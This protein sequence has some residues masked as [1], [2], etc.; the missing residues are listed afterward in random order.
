MKLQNGKSTNLSS[1]NGTTLHQMEQ[2]Q[3][4]VTLI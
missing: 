3:M 2:H 4:M 1:S